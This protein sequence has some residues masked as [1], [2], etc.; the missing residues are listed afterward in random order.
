MDIRPPLGQSLTPSFRSLNDLPGPRGIPL[1]G[2][3][4]QLKVGQQHRQL[5]GWSAL[6]GDCFKVS[7]G[8][9]TILVCSNPDDI[10]GV[11]K[12]RPNGFSRGARLEMVARELNIAGVFSSNGE[13]WRRQRMLVMSAFNPLHVKSY[14]PTLR[15]VTERFLMRWKKYAEQAQSFDLEPDLMRFT[16]DVTAGLA[17]GTDVNTIESDDGIVIQKH[18][19]DVFRMLQKRLFSA[20]PYWHWIKFAEDRKLDRDVKAVGKEVQ[21]FIESARERM[22][23][24]PALFERPRNLLEAMIAAQDGGKAALSE[25]ELAGNVVTMLLAGEDTT[26]HTLAWLFHLLYHHPDALARVVAD[27]DRTLGDDVLPVRHEQLGE[28][29]FVEACIQEAMRLRPVAPIIVAEAN[30]DTSV[31]DIAVPKGTLVMLLPRV[32]SMDNRNFANASE[33]IPDRWLGAASEANHRKVSIPFG[34]GPRMCPGRYLA[35]DEMKMVISMLVKNFHLDEIRTPDG[36][37][38]QEQLAFT[39]APV[40]LQISVRRRFV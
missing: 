21:E 36:R 30:Q 32:G 35:L 15:T 17:F 25:A 37:E 4:L 22:E 18:L 27:V 13:D 9:R 5:E 14:F 7:I 38:V 24:D 16:V 3:A 23:K 8:P 11:L 19:E 40:G 12:H 26:A 28:L 34:A 29:D 1:F 33:F 6:Y 39:L 20:F 2:N 10:S 31:A